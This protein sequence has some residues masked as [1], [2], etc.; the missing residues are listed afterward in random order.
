MRSILAAGPGTADPRPAGEALILDLP[1]VP[2]RPLADYALGEPVMTAAAAPPLAPDLAAGLRRLKLAAMRQLAPELLVT[3]RTQRWAPE[4]LLR[5][6][7]E[8]EITA[9]DASNARTRLKNAAFPVTKTLEE[10]DRSARPRSRR[11]PSTTSPPWNGSPPARISC[12]VGPAGTGKSHMLVALGAAA[13]QAGH[14][15]RY[16]TAAELIET[17]YRGLAD[18]TVGKRHR[19][20]APQ[21]PD[22]HRRGRLR[23]PGRHRRATAVPRSSPP[24]TNAALSVSPPTGP[25][26]S[27]A[28]SCPSTPPPSASSTGCCT[29]PTSSSPTATPTACAKPEPKEEPP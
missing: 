13:V 19:H 2:V 16:F 26:T 3:A 12:L 24:P 4:E 11:R 8:A 9:R 20:P 14:K 10:F 27:G 21:R 5:T 1:A 28:G 15:V 23:A 25:S 6:L 29:T 18:N 7:V 17:L 22:H